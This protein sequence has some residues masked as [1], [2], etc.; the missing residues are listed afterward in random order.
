MLSQPSAQSPIT[1]A[2]LE[3]ADVRSFAKLQQ[4]RHIHTNELVAPLIGAYLFEVLLQ[5]GDDPC[6]R[7]GGTP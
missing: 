2:F 6:L 3:A 5:R 1:D 4:L 7:K